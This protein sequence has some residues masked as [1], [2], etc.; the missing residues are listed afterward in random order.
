[1]SS[2]IKVD[3]IENVAGSGN[4]SLG[5]G[6]NL[7]VPGNNTT[8]GN[9]TVGGTLGVTGATTLANGGSAVPLSIATHVGNHELA[10]TGST[11]ANIAANNG[12][13]PFY[14]Q[15]IGAG[16]MHFQTTSADG[17]II[18]A[19]G[20][21]TKPKNV[22]FQARGANNNYI[23][24]SPIPFPTVTGNGCHNIGSH[25]DNSANTFTAPIAGRYFFHLHLGLCRTAAADGNTYP[26]FRING[27]TTQYSYF[28]SSTSGNDYANC[29]M[30]GIYSLAAND[31]FSVTFHNTNG[32]YYN[33]SAECCFSGYLMG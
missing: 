21:I 32:T 17:M 10:F 6:H 14:I 33:G 13:N 16:S 12:A 4:V 5:S 23:T 20:R 22:S 1:M 2:K 15:S 31:V 24:T 30:S 11:H 19:S 3:T 27:S 28:H 25:F 9:A 29:N 18:D 8:S 7:V 26:Y